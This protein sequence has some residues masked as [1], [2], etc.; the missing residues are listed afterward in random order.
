[1]VLGLLFL[2]GVMA[3]CASTEPRKINLMPAPAVFAGGAVDPFP[4]SQPSMSYD[5]FSMLYVTDRTPSEN[6]DESPFYFNEPGFVLRMGSARVKAGRSGLD[7]EQVRSISLSKERSGDYPMQVM[8]VNEASILSSTSSFLTRRPETIAT[9]DSTGERFAA[10]VDERLEASGVKDVYIYVPGY[11]VVFD[12]PVLIGAELWH[13][14]GYRGAFIAYSWPA[15]PSALAY[16]S[17]LETATTMARKLRVF[18]TYLSEETQAER[19]H[20]IGFS[21]G[22]RLVVH[23][24]EQLALLNAEASDQQ[25]REKLRI[26]SVVIIGG[27][28]SREAFG[29]ALTDGLL[30]IPEHTVIY[31]SSADTALVWSRRIFG[32]Q[33]VGEMWTNELPA[34][35][36]EFLRANPSLEV[37]DVTRAA[38]STGGNGHGYFRRSPW[39]SSD[40][41]TLLAY[42]LGPAQRGLVKNDELHVWQFPPDYVER[43]QEGLLGRNPDVAGGADNPDQAQLR[44]R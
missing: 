16:M 20:L 1:K 3:G 28:I 37:I 13:F 31:L 18:L 6:P 14:L 42:D 25:V 35:S 22:S 30:R 34:A 44:S 33:R 21:A 43:L 36:L 41:L 23:A 17:D 5:D 2:C 10:L 9:A 40:L 27:D 32:R 15:T 19:I 7:W 8:S 38:G 29:G 12:D 39:V 11:R 4:K 26:G 24:L